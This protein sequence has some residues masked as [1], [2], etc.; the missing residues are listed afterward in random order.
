[1]NEEI[2]ITLDGTINITV[3]FEPEVI[4]MLRKWKSKMDTKDIPLE[5]TINNLLK[6]IMIDKLSKPIAIK[7]K[8]L[9]NF[10]VTKRC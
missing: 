1:M 5:S 2:T 9:D 10:G 3:P 4:A 6:D 8:T 7:E